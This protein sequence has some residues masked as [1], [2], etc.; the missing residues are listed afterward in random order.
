M[1]RGGEAICRRT[2]SIR[3]LWTHQPLFICVFFQKYLELD[4]QIEQERR[5]VKGREKE[6][7]QREKELEKKARAQADQ[8]EGLQAQTP[9]PQW[10]SYSPASHYLELSQSVVFS[11]SGGLGGAEGESGPGAELPEAQP[12]QG[13]TDSSLSTT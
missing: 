8:R 10:S 4:D 12:Q 3:P 1:P 5:A 6:R 2:E 13:R 11:S 7:Q 9:A